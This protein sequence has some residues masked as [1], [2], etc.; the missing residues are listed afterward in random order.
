MV[1]DVF[2]RKVDFLGKKQKDMMDALKHLVKHKYLSSLYEIVVPLP[3]QVHNYV[4]LLN[5]FLIILTGFD[6]SQKY[7]HNT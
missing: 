7:L 6:S 1:L 2:P 4:F 3:A 5:K